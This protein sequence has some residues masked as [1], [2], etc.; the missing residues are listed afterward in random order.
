MDILNTRFR[1]KAG[2]KKFGDDPRWKEYKRYVLMIRCFFGVRRSISRFEYKQNGTGTL[3][4]G[5]KIDSVSH[6]CLLKVLGEGKIGR[7]G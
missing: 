7:R 1:Q 2:N 3:A 4:M 5:A 6:L